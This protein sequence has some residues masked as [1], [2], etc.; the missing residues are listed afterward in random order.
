MSRRTRSTYSV[1]LALLFAMACGKKDAPPAVDTNPPPAPPPP[2]VSVSSVDLGKSL[3]DDKSIK[4]GADTFMRRDTI[5]AV[6]S[7]DGVGPATLKALWSFGDKNTPV[8]S[9]S[10]DI[11]PTGPAKTEFHIMKPTAW[12]VGKY[13]VAIMLGSGV[14][15]TKDFEVKAK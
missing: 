10:Q 3:N 2:P 9:S 1:S 6:V 13:H 12:P 11:N 5:Y 7:T 14:A 15:Q 4:D 8:D